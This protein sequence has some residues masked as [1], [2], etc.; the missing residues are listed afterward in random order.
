E[1]GLGVTPEAGFFELGRDAGR[2]LHLIAL[3]RRE[4][5]ARGTLDED[6][7]RADDA[8]GDLRH[9]ADDPSLAD[10]AREVRLG[11]EAVQEWDG[12]AARPERRAATLGH[13]A[14]APRLHGDEHDVG[15][16]PSRISHVPQGFGL[17]DH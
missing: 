10:D 4:Y 11:I 8:R 15:A 3:E 5:D 7:P 6:A 13:L 1:I 12:E 17:D 9:R 16:E 14:E 2:V